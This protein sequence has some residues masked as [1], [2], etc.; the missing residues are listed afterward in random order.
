MAKKAALAKIQKMETRRLAAAARARK[1]AK[2]AWDTQQHSLLAGGAALG[3][4]MAESRGMNLP[5]I[6]S[7]D[8]SVLYAALAFG[9]SIFIKN[10]TVKRLA[11]GTTDGL[12][13]VAAYK[14]GR[15]GFNALF[16]YQKPVATAPATTPTA[17]YS[18]NR[19]SDYDNEEVIESGAF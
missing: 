16:S 15:D 11:E 12:L 4:G 18:R 14:A 3:M 13:G 9:L 1:V 5:T 2:A 19:Y 6:D 10:K 8:P 17:G 7:V